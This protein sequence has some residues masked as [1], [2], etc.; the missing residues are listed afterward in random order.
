MS[1]ETWQ[2]MTQSPSAGF[3]GRELSRF[4]VERGDTRS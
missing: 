4:R 3:N 2:A 1:R